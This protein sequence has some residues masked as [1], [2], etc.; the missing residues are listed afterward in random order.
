M[1]SDT[2][3]SDANTFNQPIICFYRYLRMLWPF[4]KKE[5]KKLKKVI[6]IGKTFM[7]LSIFYIAFGVF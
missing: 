3:S 6:K 4:P 2:A 1:V 7:N 5:K